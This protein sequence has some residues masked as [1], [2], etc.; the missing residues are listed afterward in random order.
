MIRYKNRVLPV[1][2]QWDG[3]EQYFE[4]AKQSIIDDIRLNGLDHYDG[5][6][7]LHDMP[8]EEEKQ[9]DGSPAQEKITKSSKSTKSTKANKSLPKGNTPNMDKF[10]DKGGSNDNETAS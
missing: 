2:I 5:Y 6:A 9:W 7:D 8:T 1:W 4:R 10:A 3:D